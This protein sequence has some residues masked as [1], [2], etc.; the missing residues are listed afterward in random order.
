[1]RK[2][3]IFILNRMGLVKA[4]KAALEGFTGSSDSKERR[5][6]YMDFISFLLAFI[7]AMVI[8]GF[9]GKLLWND[10]IVELFTCVKPARSVW[11]VIGLYIFVSLLLPMN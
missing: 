6:A 9:V 4:C 5:N 1:M 3:R 2:I 7:L 10:V 11:H 8:L